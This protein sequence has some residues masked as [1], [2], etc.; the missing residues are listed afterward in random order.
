MTIKNV[1]IIGGSGFVGTAV[2]N[3]LA[4]LDINVTVPTR[5]RERT[6]ALIAL[7]N[8]SMVQANVHDLEQLAKLMVGQDAVINLVGILHGGD[9]TAPY[10]RKFAEAHVELPKKIVAAAK[11]AGISRLLHMSALKASADAPS[12]YL[13]SKADGEA[14]VKAAGLDLTIFRPSVM[15]GV[16]DSFLSTFA[17]LL[18]LLPRFYVGYGQARFQPVFVGDVA[19]V[20]VRSLLDSNAVG[21]T[22]ELVGTKVYTL[23]QIIEYVNE[24]TGARTTIKDLPEF[25]ALLQAGLLSLLPNPMLSPDNL[26][27]MEVD[28]VAPDAVMPYGIVPAPLEAIAPTYLLG[29]A[30]KRNLDRF[31]LTAGR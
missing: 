10:S 28:S 2:A 29:V 23:R 25:W 20:I 11:A 18:K 12:E 8:V 22:Y 5:R 4:K 21:Q 31:R 3:R 15:F 27:S 6:K 30:I 19:E 14:A 16:G 13:R 24:V 1:L 26:R 17:K 7:P 9:L